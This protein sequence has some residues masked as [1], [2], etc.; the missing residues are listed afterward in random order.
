MSYELYCFYKASLLSCHSQISIVL[1]TFLLVL[2]T[3]VAVQILSFEGR[4][5]NSKIAISHKTKQMLAGMY[6]YYSDIIKHRLA[7]ILTV[8]T[9]FYLHVT[10]KKVLF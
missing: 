5:Y 10:L 9:A 3:V 2:H 1:I 4:I 7:V 6:M 8:V